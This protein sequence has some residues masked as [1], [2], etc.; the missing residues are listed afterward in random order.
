M[1]LIF[2]L[3]YYTKDFINKGQ[4]FNWYL[5]TESGMRFRPCFKKL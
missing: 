2:R 3:A 4:C 1:K 5:L